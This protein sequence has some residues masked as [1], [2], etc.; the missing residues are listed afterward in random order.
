[1]GLEA[2]VLSGDAPGAVAAAARAAGVPAWRGGAT[3]ADKASRI[4]ELRAAGR[5]PLMV[6]DGINDA[7]A[8]AL[9][10]ASASPSDGTDL[11]RQVADVVLQGGR[12]G[13]LADAVATA[14]RAMRLSRQNIG[15]SLA[16]NA[17]AI[18]AS[19]LGLITP[20]LAAVVMAAS[21][22]TVILNAMRAGQAG[23][24]CADAAPRVPHGPASGQDVYDAMQA[25]TSV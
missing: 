19:M 11:A 8:L 17:V 1:L 7:G 2:E 9:A 14:R 13:A 20:L 16:Y 6:G 15:L 5:R 25:P 4:Q 23:R 22:L 24:T 10:H 21:S 12:V 18:P 3:P